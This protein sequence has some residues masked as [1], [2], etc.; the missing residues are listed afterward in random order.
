MLDA[1]FVGSA[2]F[3]SLQLK[4]ERILFANALAFLKTPV[5]ELNPPTNQFNPLIIFPKAPS[6]KSN[7]FANNPETNCSIAHNAPFTTFPRRFWNILLI[8]LPI[9]PRTFSKAQ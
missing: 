5:T 1:H 6:K 4:N 8:K 2:H 3:S 7:I 9:F